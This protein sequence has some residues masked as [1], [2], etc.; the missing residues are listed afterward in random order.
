MPHLSFNAYRRDRMTSDRRFLQS[1]TD[2]LRSR[3]LWRRHSLRKHCVASEAMFEEGGIV[4]VSD[5]FGNHNLELG[6]RSRWE[7]WRDKVIYLLRAW[8]LPVELV[9]DAVVFFSYTTVVARLG[10]K[11]CGRNQRADHPSQDQWGLK[12]PFLGYCGHYIKECAEER[13]KNFASLYTL[14][15]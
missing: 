9:D 10:R 8:L 13:K 6:D 14:H 4:K 11:D 1:K 12:H 2:L 7:F 3:P 15:C 5:L